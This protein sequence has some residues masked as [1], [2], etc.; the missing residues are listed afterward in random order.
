MKELNINVNSFK[1]IRI[2]LS[3]LMIISGILFIGIH[4]PKPGAIYIIYSIFSILAGLYF[5]T[6]FSGVDKIIIRSG[7]DLLRIK[8]LGRIR[9]REMGYREI[10]KIYLRKAEII[11][12]RRGQSELYYNLEYLETMKKNLVYE[13]IIQVSG[14]NGIRVE[15]QFG[16]QIK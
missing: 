12:Q 10:D 14:E 1:I 15:R 2:S 11:I 7:A 5:I 9:E 16:N 8:W 3:I 13:F 4:Y 6:G